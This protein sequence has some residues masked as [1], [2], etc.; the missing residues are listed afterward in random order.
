MTNDDESTFEL[1]FKIISALQEKVIFNPYL[2]KNE[3]QTQ[4]AF[5]NLKNAILNQPF[6]INQ[7]SSQYIRKLFSDMLFWL[8]YENICQEKEQETSSS[9]AAQPLNST[10]NSSNLAA[11]SEGSENV[12]D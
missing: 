9:I 4:R 3:V 2:Q 12:H 10:T 7:R 1:W 6:Q 5:I 11:A 8:T